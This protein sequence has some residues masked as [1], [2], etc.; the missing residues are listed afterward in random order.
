MFAQAGITSIQLIMENN[1][2][3]S[4]SFPTHFFELKNLTVLD[5]RNNNL[6]ELPAAIGGLQNLKVLNV[7]SNQLVSLPPSSMIVHISSLQCRPSS[8][9]KSLNCNLPLSY[10][11]PIHSFKQKRTKRKNIRY[12]N[13]NSAHCSF[14]TEYQHWSN[15]L[16][17]EP[18]N[19]SLHLVELTLSV[20]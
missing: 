17:E 15:L 18:S 2:L 4:A 6:T 13:A 19:V 7:A 14:T 9:V 20:R 12:Q 5:L 11:I 10:T 1:A 3:H 8:Q 16:I